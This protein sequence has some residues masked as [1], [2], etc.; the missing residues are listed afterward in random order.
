MGFHIL[1]GLMGD[2]EGS[3]GITIHFEETFQ[4]NCMSWAKFHPIHKFAS[5][6]HK[7]VLA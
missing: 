1:L 2:F 3:L 6:G 7:R 5:P 4:M